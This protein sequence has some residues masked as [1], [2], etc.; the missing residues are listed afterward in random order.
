MTGPDAGTN[1]Y[2]SCGRKQG[3][4][5]SIKN[6]VEG[7]MVYALL[8]EA[9][10]VWQKATA[11]S[12]KESKPVVITEEKRKESKNGVHHSHTS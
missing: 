5:L 3:G 12:C 9:I 4:N 1:P 7:H 8:H 10:S 2:D 6:L 11:A